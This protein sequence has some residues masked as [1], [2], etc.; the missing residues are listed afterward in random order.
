MKQ[1]SPEKKMLGAREIEMDSVKRKTDSSL[2][3]LPAAI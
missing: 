2:L 1:F 3:L